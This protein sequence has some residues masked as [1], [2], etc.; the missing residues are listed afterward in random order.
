MRPPATLPDDRQ[1]VFR[2]DRPAIL[3]DALRIILRYRFF[4]A[5]ASGEKTLE[6]RRYN[7]RWNERV[8]RVGRQV[9]LL[10]GYNPHPILTGR[11]VAY[12]TRPS[13]ESI[14][15]FAPGTRCAVMSI[16]IDPARPSHLAGG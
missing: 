9:V 5:F 12:A 6:W 2:L 13:P 11:I 8:C 1:G 3:P 4:D 16:A 15:S 10:R 7:H 14:T